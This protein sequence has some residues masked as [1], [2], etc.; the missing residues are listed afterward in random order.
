MSVEMLKDDFLCQEQYVIELPDSL[1]NAART[2]EDFGFQLAFDLTGQ[3]GELH[4]MADIP[5]LLRVYP[6]RV[7]KTPLTTESYC[8][9]DGDYFYKSAD[10]SDIIVVY[11]PDKIPKLLVDYEISQ[12]VKL[13]AHAA[14]NPIY[15]PTI[16]M[17]PHGLTPP[18]AWA[19]FH[20][21]PNIP[22]RPRFFHA[23]EHDFVAAFEEERTNASQ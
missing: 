19:P 8:S 17:S 1:A 23:A 15:D 5:G 21:W 13:V 14:G 22:T 11:E 18:A 7:F 20:L 10:I 3:S 2:R 16:N 12:K 9:A 4:L 6:F